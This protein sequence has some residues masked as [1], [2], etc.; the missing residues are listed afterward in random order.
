MRIRATVAA[1]SGALA[2]SALAVPAAQAEDAPKAGGLSAFSGQAQSDDVVGDTKITNVVINGGK[3]IVLGTT[4]AK[5]ITV[6]VTATDN[7]GI[8]DA[9]VALWHGSSVDDPDGFL[10]TNEETATCTASSATTTCKHTITVDPQADLYK[11]S[12]AGTW[13]VAAIAWAKDG[14]YMEKDAYK[15]HRVQRFSKL[16]VNAAPEPVVKGKPITVTGKLSRANWET[17]T[18]AGYTGQP[19]KLQFRKAGTST[20]TTLKTVTTNSTGNLKTTVTAASDGYWRWSFAG[21]STTPA[22]S[23]AGDYVDVR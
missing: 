11:N 18:Y 22:V 10:L 19:V 12:L 1:V 3:N 6:S 13:K 5:T 9:D 4:A 21:T 14:D 16:T 20:Y 15:T 2:L 23:A 8:D 17:S 7:S